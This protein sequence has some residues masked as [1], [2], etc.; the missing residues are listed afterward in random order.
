MRIAQS[1]L[2]ILTALFSLILGSC[3]QG[4]SEL[5]RKL[6]EIDATPTG[7][8]NGGKLYKLKDLIHAFAGGDEK[9]ERTRK[10]RAE[11]KRVEIQNLRSHGELIEVDK[12]RSLGEQIMMAVRNKILNMPM[13][14]DE[15]EKCLA[16]LLSLREIDFSS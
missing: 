13:T 7:T 16:D 11:A 5:T 14:D 3:E 10:L 12:V 9:A 1:T 8:K 6:S 4:R 15:K 2:S